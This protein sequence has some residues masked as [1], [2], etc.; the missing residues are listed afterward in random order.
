MTRIL[1]TVLDE[2]NNNKLAAAL[3]E[4]PLGRT[5][6]LVPKFYRGAVV[7]NVLVLPDEAKAAAILSA[8][9]TAG[10]TIGYTT[11]VLTSAVVAT[12][13]CKVDAKG[14]IAFFG[15]DAVTEAEVVYVAVEGDLVTREIDVVAG[16]GVG[17]LPSSDVGVLL[18]SA[19]VLAGGALGAKTVLP[20]VSA[21]P[22]AG[23][24]A[25]DLNGDQ[26]LFAVADAVTRASITY[27]KIPSRTVEQALRASV[28][29]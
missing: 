12:N 19:T 27:R 8:V 26:V 29:L 23:N 18:L 15:T 16:T 5:M 28:A 9:R 24:V 1:K 20:R 21:A 4:L 22:A 3:A 6:N 14:D 2:G 17:A 11:P 7:A 10:T 13:Q 25:L